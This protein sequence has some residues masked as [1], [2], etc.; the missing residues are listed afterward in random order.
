MRYEIITRL[1]QNLVIRCTHNKINPA[2]AAAYFIASAISYA[3]GIFHKSHKGFISLK[4]ARFRVLFSGGR[5]WIR[6][7]E[8]VDG[9]FTVCSLW[10]LGNS[11]IFNFP[12]DCFL[13]TLTLIREE[14]NHSLHQGW[15]WWT[16]EITLRVLSVLG[17]RCFAT[18]PP[19]H[20]APKNNPP[21]CFLYGAH[22]HRVRVRP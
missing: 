18:V 13:N 12:P 21:D 6:T 4:K 14:S 17:H 10:P 22:P 16:D 20:F 11:P 3:T 2:Y 15:S 8:V 7:T 1:R 19:S 9:R 5:E